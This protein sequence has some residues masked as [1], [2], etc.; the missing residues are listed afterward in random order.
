MQELAWLH[1]ACRSW[2]LLG[3]SVASA[4]MCV[5]TFLRDSQQQWCV[6]RAANQSSKC[7]SCM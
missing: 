4:V 6:S 7:H 3:G 2:L 5:L 1:A